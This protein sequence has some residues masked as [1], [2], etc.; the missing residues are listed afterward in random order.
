[1]TSFTMDHVNGAFDAQIVSALP[2]NTRQ[3]VVTILRT[4]FLEMMREDG[5]E[6]VVD[7][8]GRQSGMPGV[9]TWTIVVHAHIIKAF[10]TMAHE[11]RHA[12]DWRMIDTRLDAPAVDG[13]P[14][15]HMIASNRKVA[16]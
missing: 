15:A 13:E 12:R 6:A 3:H 11:L 8:V 14:S 9:S 7:L 1:M 4:A 10:V 5:P 16:Q 2:A